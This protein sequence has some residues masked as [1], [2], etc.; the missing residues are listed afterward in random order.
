MLFMQTKSIHF[1]ES[2]INVLVHHSAMRINE[3]RE[4]ELII[5]MS[6]VQCC[7]HV[8]IRRIAKLLLSLCSIYFIYFIY[9]LCYLFYYN[10]VVVF[11]FD[12]N[13]NIVVLKVFFLNETLCRNLKRISEFRKSMRFLFEGNVFLVV[14]VLRMNHSIP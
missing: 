2:Q 3:I 1:C 5:V 13:K 6:T 14:V 7:C 8:Y 10:V 4:F 9:S 12:L 11:H